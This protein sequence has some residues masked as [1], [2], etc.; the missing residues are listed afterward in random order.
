MP[1]PHLTSSFAPEHL[2]IVHWCGW[3]QKNQNHLE[4][5]MMV[6]LVGCC[7]MNEA[8][9]RVCQINEQIV[10]LPDCTTTTPT[11]LDCS[12]VTM[13]QLLLLQ[14]FYCDNV[15]VAPKVHL[16]GSTARLLP[17]YIC[18]AGLHTTIPPP[19]WSRLVH[20]IFL[21]VLTESHALVDWLSVVNLYFQKYI[22]RANKSQYS[23]IEIKQ[24]QNTK[25]AY[26]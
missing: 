25:R 2:A 9:A 15:T 16:P 12:H 17:C 10:P 1:L 24:Q 19:D 3:E 23:D 22:Y 7:P 14:H 26:I 5:R 6:K 8:G 18:T 4:R 13:L 21:T 20:M 11:L